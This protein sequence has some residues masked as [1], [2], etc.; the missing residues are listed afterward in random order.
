MTAL[1]FFTLCRHQSNSLIFF[2]LIPQ[3][4]PRG[5]HN[6]G[7]TISGPLQRKKQRSDV[8]GGSLKIQKPALSNRQH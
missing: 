6:P 5:A 1:T 8:G 4:R 3:V 2:P 7:Q